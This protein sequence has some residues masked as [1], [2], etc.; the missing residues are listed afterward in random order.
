MSTPLA[1]FGNYEVRLN[2]GK[3][4]VFVNDVRTGASRVFSVPTAVA[5]AE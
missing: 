4:L 3:S 2:R 1:S 5:G